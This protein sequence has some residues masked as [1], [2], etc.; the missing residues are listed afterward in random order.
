[1][2]A[3][4]DVGQTIKAGDQVS[5]IGSITGDY[6][7]N[8]YLEGWHYY[9]EQEKKFTNDQSKLV[10]H[11]FN[12]EELSEKFRELSDEEKVIGK[13]AYCEKTISM[14]DRFLEKRGLSNIFCEEC[15][16]EYTVTT[17]YLGGEEYI[18]SENDGWNMHRKN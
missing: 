1:M 11:R 8:E 15:V 14:G 12:A 10:T 13:C 16:E 17:F 18:G 7:I 2:I 5:V 4:K 3:I 6:A 9:S